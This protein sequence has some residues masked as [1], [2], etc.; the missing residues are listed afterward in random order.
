MEHIVYSSLLAFC[1][2]NVENSFDVNNESTELCLESMDPILNG[3][4]N[5]IDLEK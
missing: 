3:N 1:K 4:I 2:K 5:S